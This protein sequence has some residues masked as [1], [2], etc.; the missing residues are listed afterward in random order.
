METKDI[1]EYEGLYKISND[2]NVYATKRQGSPGGIVKQHLNNKTGYLYVILYKNGKGKTYTIHRLIAL[3][4]IDNIN[5]H[6]I[7]DHIDRNRIN[8]NIENLR[9]ATYSINN[10]N[11]RSKGGVAIDKFIK[12]GKEYIYYKVTL[13]CKSKRFKTKEEAMQYL[14]DE[15]D[16]TETMQEP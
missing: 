7:V 5:C 4:F 10:S 13:N 14:K 2:G 9:W 12:N 1:I 6:P 15:Y 11:R 16:K 3:H 8:N